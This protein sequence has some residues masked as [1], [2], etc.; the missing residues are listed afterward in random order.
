[1]SEF[2]AAG[3]AASAPSASPRVAAPNPLNFSWQQT[4]LR[5]KD[6]S[7]SVPFYCDNFGFTL[8]HK[9][10]FPQWSFSLYFLAILEDGEVW[11]HT[12]GSKEA[13]QAVWTFRGVCLELTHNHGSESDVSFSVNNGNVEPH[14]GFG[15]IAVMT[16]DVYAAS[17][18]LEKAGVAFQKRP[19][20]GRMKGL[21]FVLDPDGY[22]VEIVSRSAE[23]SVQNKYTF[24]QTMIRIK[25]P[26]KAIPFYTELFGMSLLRESHYSDFSLFFMAQIPPGTPLP[27]DASDAATAGEYIRQ[28]FPPVLELTHNH[29]TE[30]NEDFKYHNGNDQ[31]AGQLRGFGHIGFLVD[32]LEAACTFLTEKG[33]RFKKRPEEGGMRGLAFVYDSDNYWVEVIQRGGLSLVA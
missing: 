4:M 20:E 29:G 31:D 17:A 32:D 13:E 21:A 27:P 28:M 15:H 11:P 33:V 16:R 3:E 12:P 24:A 22:W 30:K 18:E 19:D 2:A 14:R 10:D 1:M 23:S 9:Y 26:A 8:L 25:D 7:K 6:P 5:I